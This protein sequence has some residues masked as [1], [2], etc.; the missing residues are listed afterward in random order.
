MRK[1]GNC[2]RGIYYTVDCDIYIAQKWYKAD[3]KALQKEQDFFY[4]SG[5]HI[6]TDIQETAKYL[7]ESGFTAIRI[8]KGELVLVKVEYDIVLASGID[9]TA[10]VDVAARM[11]IIKEYSPSKAKELLTKANQGKQQKRIYK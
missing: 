3:I 2:F 1:D 11:R 8:L 5:F 7:N 4:L 9:R 6:L 10:K